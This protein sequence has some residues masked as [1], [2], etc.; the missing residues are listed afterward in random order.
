MSQKWGSIAVENKSRSL[1]SLWS[2]NTV[3]LLLFTVIYR[4]TS[5][6]TFGSLYYCWIVI[7]FYSDGAH[8]SILLPLDSVL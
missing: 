4:N 7:S 3:C 1:Q 6:S 5:G 8:T 2:G